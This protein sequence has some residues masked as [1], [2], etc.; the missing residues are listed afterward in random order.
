MHIVSI[1]LF[2][3]T[4]STLQRHFLGALKRLNISFW[5]KDPR[6]CISCWTITGHI[7]FK[8][9]QR[10]L[11]FEGKL[12][13]LGC[14]N[15]GKFVYGRAAQGI[16]AKTDE[17]IVVKSNHLGSLFVQAVHPPGCSP[18]AWEKSGGGQAEVGQMKPGWMCA[19]T[20]RG[21]EDDEKQ[22]MHR[23]RF[24]NGEMLLL[25]QLWSL[26]QQDMFLE[27]AP[28][29]FLLLEKVTWKVGLSHLSLQADSNRNKYKIHFWLNCLREVTV[30]S[31][32]VQFRNWSNNFMIA[33]RNWYDLERKITPNTLRSF[34]SDS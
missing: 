24:E 12:F 16:S 7:S 22:T 17:M 4:K 14:V 34:Y 13:Y 30:H 28:V 5:T 26:N 2:S 3:L 31:N 19:L 8:M 1:I 33:M 9:F 18:F 29:P 20:S 25:L 6:A 23:E 15:K 21:L 11:N 10:R 27:F 32:H